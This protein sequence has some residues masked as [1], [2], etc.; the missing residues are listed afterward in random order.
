MTKP[1]P[2][3]D[4]VANAIEAQT[5]DQQRPME[6]AVL[7]A[8]ASVANSDLS[9]LKHD[10]LGLDDDVFAS[11]DHHQFFAAVKALDAAG[12]HVDQ[13]TVAERLS[14]TK[15]DQFFGS[16]AIDDGQIRTYMKTL[17]D[18]A[19][20]RRLQHIHRRFGDAVAGADPDDAAALLNEL[21][22]DVFD[23]ER[24][25]R[26]VRP[27]KYEADLLDETLLSIEAPKPGRPTG[28]AHLDDVLHG[29]LRP[30]LAMVAGTPGAG[31]TTFLKQMADQLAEGGAPVLFF[32]YEQSA[33]ELR[34]KTLSR[35]SSIE[36]RQLKA[37]NIGASERRHLMQ[38]IDQYRRFGSRMKI[39]EG[40]G[41]YTVSAIRMLALQER[42]RMD[43]SP[44]VI[45]D[46]LQILPTGDMEATDKRQQVDLLVSEL[47]RL[48]RDLDTTVIA[49]SSMSRGQYDKAQLD[50]FKESGGI[51]YT[52][53]IAIVLKV[54]ANDR[55]AE[56]RV[57]MRVVK[58][59]NGERA[60]IDMRYLTIYDKFIDESSKPISYSQSMGNDQ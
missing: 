11:R 5:D 26:I 16:V 21:Q 20:L 32:S 46:Y 58:N 52:A 35:L 55:P 45:I 10:I 36:N 56:R 41:R 40:D 24:L 54:E 37:G 48:A 29:G 9:D 51:E 50:A 7:S 3:S 44:I 34:L 39:I 19:I 23:A 25:S 57:T 8:L 28:F 18:R 49:I 4:L 47:R 13:L 14:G 22:K 2:L 38:A 27:T 1:D 6:A 42:A 33:E 60:D 12:D 43:Q 31:K 53:D 15:V 30:G 17:S 59:R